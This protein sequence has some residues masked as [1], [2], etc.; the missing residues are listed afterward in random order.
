M[1]KLAFPTATQ[2]TWVVMHFLFSFP[3]EGEL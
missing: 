3:L 2:A 1:V